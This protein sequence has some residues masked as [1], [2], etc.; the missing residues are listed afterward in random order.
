MASTYIL[1]AVLFVQGAH[2]H[3]LYSQRND[4]KWSLSRHATDSEQ[5]RTIYRFG[6]LFGGASWLVAASLLFDQPSTRFIFY[7]AIVTVAFEWL[8]AIV[9]INSQRIVSLHATLA[10]IVWISSILTTLLGIIY[11]PAAAWQRGIASIIAFAAIS[12]VIYMYFRRDK[13]WRLQYISIY[14]FFA[15]FF[16]LSL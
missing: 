5:S 4:R 13:L 8:Q 2:S 6:H 11:L 10:Y 9:L 3:L 7:I 15:A 12:T 16:V 1:L 14:G